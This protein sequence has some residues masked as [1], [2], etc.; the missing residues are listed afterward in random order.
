MN[1]KRLLGI[2]L[3]IVLVLW[4][5]PV[6]CMTARADEPTD[7]HLNIGGVQVTSANKSGTGWSFTPGT[8]NS[9]A[10]LSLTGATITSS[11]S[12]AIKYDSDAEY[13]LKIEFSGDNTISGDSTSY[14]YGIE[15][16][17]KDIIIAGSGKLTVSGHYGIY[18]LGSVTISGGE[19]ITSSTGNGDNYGICT[20]NGDVIISGGAVTATGYRD[21]IRAQEGSVTIGGAETIVNASGTDPSTPYSSSNG[22]YSHNNIT[23]NGGVVS[24]SAGGCGLNSFGSD[25]KISGGKVTVNVNRTGIYTYY[26]KVSITGGIVEVIC[27]GDGSSGMFSDHI[28]VSGGSVEVSGKKYG[29]GSSSNSTIIN[30][31]SISGGCFIAKG[32]TKALNSK[33]INGI[34]GTGWSNTEGTENGTD[35]GISDQER[36]FDHKKVQFL[37]PT[38][39]VPPKANTLTYNEEAQYLVTDGTAYGNYIM[40]Y[41][42]GDD[43]TT[44]PTSGWDEGIP[45]K[46][47]VGTYYVWYRAKDN[48]SNEHSVSKCVPVT[49]GKASATVI[50]PPTSSGPLTYTGQPQA[51]LATAG[52]ADE[53][54]TMEY[55]IGVNETNAPDSG[56]STGIPEG[57]DAK[58]Y[59]VWYRATANNTDKNVKT[60][61]LSALPLPLNRS[62]LLL[63]LLL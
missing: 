15:N 54:G 21:G 36:Q 5:T 2:I 63:L 39:T 11:N 20:E 30:T 26:G 32:G 24:A 35:I 1:K 46:I 58:T 23:I 59:Y 13:P 4:L 40:E 61:P 19:V 27:T 3:S 34:K 38:V 42:F 45:Q 6:V 14:R 55:A 52:T 10:I 18:S 48:T 60:A 43:E 22:I 31:I 33:V 62:R 51:L 28:D 17:S 37:S 41:A 9:P 25:I 8:S 29:V 50:T 12:A 44:E 57:T 7:Y 16:G 47:N 53:N 49:I 56:W